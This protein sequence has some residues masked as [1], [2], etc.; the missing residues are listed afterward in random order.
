MMSCACALWDASSQRACWTVRLSSFV[1]VVRE[2]AWGQ[3]QDLQ[4]LL[5]SLDASWKKPCP[6]GYVRTVVGIPPSAGH[7]LA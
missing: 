5:K 3:M 1:R 2:P 4:E 6:S 7:F